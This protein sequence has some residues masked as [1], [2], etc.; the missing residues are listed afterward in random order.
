V[1]AILVEPRISGRVQIILGD[2]MYPF[3]IDQQPDEEMMSRFQP[4]IGN[5]QLRVSSTK[6]FSMKDFGTGV[7]GSFTVSAACNE[8]DE[9]DS[10]FQQAAT[11]VKYYAGALAQQAFEEAESQLRQMLAQRG[12]PDAYKF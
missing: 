6:D 11:L 5:A 7:S 3:A 8:G 12:R 2:E 10:S 9:D 4:L 1:D